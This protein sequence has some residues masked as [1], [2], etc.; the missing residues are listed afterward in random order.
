MESTGA[1][2]QRNSIVILA[3]DMKIPRQVYWYQFFH[4]KTNSW[5]SLVS[6]LF[7]NT[8]RY[9]ENWLTTSLKRFILPFCFLISKL[10]RKEWKRLN[11]AY[12]RSNDK[13]FTYSEPRECPHFKS[14]LQYLCTNHLHSFKLVKVFNC[15]YHLFYYS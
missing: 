9:R 6:I 11:N 5:F 13:L 4:W 8:W 12:K 10:W 15:T 7:P 2:S 1:I 3:N 14:V